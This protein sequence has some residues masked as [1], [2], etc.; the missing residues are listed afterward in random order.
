[1]FRMPTALFAAPCWSGVR[2]D[3]GVGGSAEG[4]GIISDAVSPLL[5]ESE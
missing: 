1:L 2:V 5:L 4:N 3:G